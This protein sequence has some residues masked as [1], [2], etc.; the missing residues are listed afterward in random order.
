MLSLA[1]DWE[2][3]PVNVV[4]GIKLPKMP[5]GRVRYLQPTELHAVLAACPKWL[6][7]I[8]AL[9][10]FTGMRRSEVLGLRWLDIDRKGERILLP[11]TKNGDARIVWLNRL[12]C[13]VI[14]SMKPGAPPDRVFS[15]DITPENVSLAFC[16]P[17]ATL[18]LLISV[19]MISDTRRHHGC[20]CPVPICRM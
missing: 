7:P 18:E 20:A 12:A 3:I 13:D 1:V 14:D 15:P 11:H 17:A 16:V 8:V 6:R 9:L 4:R 19:S 10:A 2:L 5:A